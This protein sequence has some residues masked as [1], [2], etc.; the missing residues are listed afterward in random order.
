MDRPDA[1]C[2]EWPD[3][4]SAGPC[5]EAEGEGEQRQPN[6]P[7]HSSGRHERPQPVRSH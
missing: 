5:G 2:Q 4:S 7:G 3:R 1:R 6:R